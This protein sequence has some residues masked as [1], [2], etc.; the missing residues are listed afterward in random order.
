[1]LTTLVAAATLSA[2]ALPDAALGQQYIPYG[3]QQSAV[4]QNAGYGFGP[5]PQNALVQNR[6]Y[7]PRPAG[8]L[9]TPLALRSYQ[10]NI[11]KYSLRPTKRLGAEQGPSIGTEWWVP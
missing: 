7:G 6:G 11:L 4:I 5:G 3:R 1:M 10:F 8:R 2:L 9:L